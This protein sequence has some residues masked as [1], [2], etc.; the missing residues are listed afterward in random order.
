MKSE[1]LLRALSFVDEKYIEEAAEGL[2]PTRTLRRR[3]RIPQRMRG[4][5][6]LKLKRRAPVFPKG[7]RKRLI[8][9]GT[10]R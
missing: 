10:G 3:G 2:P 8:S 7:R 4:P 1:E 9:G 6:S 5:S